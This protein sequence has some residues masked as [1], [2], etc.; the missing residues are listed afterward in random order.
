MSVA[1]TPT[2]GALASR[3]AIGVLDKAVAVL[4]AIEAGAGT[5]GELVEA[6]GLARATAYRLATALEAHGLLA[7]GVGG[8]WRLGLRLVALGSAATGDLPLRDALQD[9]G[10]SALARLRD[11]T[12]ESAQLYVRV[13][14][15]RVCIEAADSARELRT[16]VPVGASLPLTAGS[17]GKILMAWAPEQDVERLLAHLERL[18]PNTVTDPNRLRTQLEAARRRGWA[19]SAGEREAGVGSVSAPIRDADGVILAAVSVSGP[20]H[21]IGRSPGKRYSPEVVAAARAIE[22]ALGIAAR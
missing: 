18:T 20:T 22:S 4:D 6:T 17:A 1:R 13:G 10:R 9:V 2:A 3:S 15:R 5:L 14:D 11:T 16:I 21:R 12:G 7:R 8:R 19:E